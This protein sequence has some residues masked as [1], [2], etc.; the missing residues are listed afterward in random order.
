MDAR[1]AGELLVRK[2]TTKPP[3]GAQVSARIVRTTPWWTTE[4]EGPAFDAALR[5][6]EKGYGRKPVL[7]GAGGSIGFVRPFSDALPGVPCLLTGVEDPGCGAHSENESLHLGD[8]K[9]SM[10]SAVHLFDELGAVGL[11]GLK[12]A[13][14]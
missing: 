12:R 3:A 13:R 6:L 8:W 9:K 2:L 1:E 10:R 7:I 5:A 11:A 4:P 14:R